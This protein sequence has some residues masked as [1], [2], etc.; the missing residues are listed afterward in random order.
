MKSRRDVGLLAL[1]A[2]DAGAVIAR[3][4]VIHWD[5][6]G[7]CSDPYC[8]TVMGRSLV[9]PRSLVMWRGGRLATV[10]KENRW[11]M[12][13]FIAIDIETRCRHCDN[14]M[15]ARRSIWWYRAKAEIAL[16]SRTWF[17]TLTLSPYAVTTLKNRLRIA[18]ANSA[19]GDFDG[20]PSPEQFGRLAS[21][22]GKEITLWLK[23]LR[24]AEKSRF[25]YFMVVEAHK[26]GLP[27]WHVLLH[28]IRTEP[29]LRHRVLKDQWK[30][31]FTDFKLVDPTD[32]AAAGY[33]SK[34]LAKSALARVRASARYGSGLDIER[35]LSIEPH[36]MGVRESLTP[37]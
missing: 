22:G 36:D 16:S 32:T 35:S 18:D 5:I 13:G 1:R 20:R 37:T 26:S 34:Y 4:M 21:E 7:N 12:D 3:P 2:L 25:R 11:I 15:K 19:A 24:K 28:E 6:S 30:L 17:G 29:P 8:R 27:H 33:V 10:L 23:R 9:K 31:G 14:C